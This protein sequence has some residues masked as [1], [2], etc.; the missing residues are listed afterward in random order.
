MDRDYLVRIANAVWEAILKTSMSEAIGA[1]GKRLAAI[2]SRECVSA[3]IQIM[4]VLMATSEATSSPTRLREACEDVAQRLRT[5]TAE[6]RKGGA[7][8]KLFNEVWQATMQ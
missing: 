1:D 7:A 5:A 3:L 4:A 6:A 8:M 2:Q